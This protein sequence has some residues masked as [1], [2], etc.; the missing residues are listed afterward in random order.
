MHACACMH[1]AH[2]HTCQTAFLYLRDQRSLHTHTRKCI[3]GSMAAPCVYLGRHASFS[4]RVYVLHRRLTACGQ[5]PGNLRICVCFVCSYVC[6]HVCMCL[7]HTTRS[8]MYACTHVY[9][10]PNAWHTLGPSV[11]S[12][13]AF[14]G[15]GSC[16]CT[17]SWGT[18][19]SLGRFGSAQ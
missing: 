19:G 13:E 18:S 17:G 2:I 11:T 16:T 15:V 4:R 6:M 7:N 14:C 12:A 9:A 8:S 1:I 3:T 10:S 5:R